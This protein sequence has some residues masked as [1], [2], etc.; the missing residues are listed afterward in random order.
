MGI[1]T[2]FGGSVRVGQSFFQPLEHKFLD[3]MVPKIPS[4]LQTYHLTLLTIPW[5]GFIVLGG[6]LGQK[7]PAWLWLSSIMIAAQFFTDLLDGEVGRRRNTG[8][9]RWGFYMDHLLDYFFLCAILIQYLLVLPP[10]FD[11]TQ[12]FLLAIFAGYMVH[13]FLAFGATNI[14][15]VC[16]MGIGPTEVR[17]VFIFINALLARFGVTH[18]KFLVPYVLAVA[19]V[20]LIVTVYKTQKD[21]WAM[22]MKEKA[23]GN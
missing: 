3:W 16:F 14:L 21:I 1:T 10:P 22:D 18:M 23:E 17:L 5:C 8:L 4:W 15:Q 13:A 19:A 20:G 11:A 9:R 6:Y 12:F 7:N 2:K